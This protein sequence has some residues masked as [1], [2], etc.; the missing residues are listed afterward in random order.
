[1]EGSTP[2]EVT[3]RNRSFE[4]GS[5]GASTEEI[6]QKVTKVVHLSPIFVSSSR[7]AIGSDLK[8]PSTSK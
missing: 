5:S 1:M 4:L 7:A 8:E 2:A 3:R 6:E